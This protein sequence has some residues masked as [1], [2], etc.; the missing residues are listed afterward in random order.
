MAA[1]YRGTVLKTDGTPL[2]DK[3]A[4]KGMRLNIIAGSI[5]MMFFVVFAGMPFTMFMNAIG[6]SGALIGAIL[7]VQQLAM[8]LQVPSA[9]ISERLPTRK[10]FWAFVTLPHRFLWIIPSVIP[11]FLL[12]SDP[13]MGWIIFAAVAT[14]S[15][16]AQM[17][18]ASWWSWMADFIPS[19]ARSSFWGLRH[20]VVSASGLGAMLL[21][22]FILDAFPDPRQPG[23]SLTGFIIVL[24]AAAIMGTVDILLHMG[25]PEPKPA[26]KERGAGFLTQVLAPLRNRDFRWLTL[27][28]A[29]WAFGVGLINQFGSIWLN[30]TFGI[31]YSGLS[32]TVIGAMLG[33]SLAGL[34]WAYVMDRVGARNFGA[35]MMFVAPIVGL[36][37][38]FPR[39]TTLT[40]DLPFLPAVH[41]SQPVVILTISGFFGGLLYSG[42]ALAQISLASSLLPAS[43]RTMAMAV[44]WSIVGAVGA[45]GPLVAGNLLDF[46][47]A[48]PV[49]WTLPTGT[50]LGFYHVLILAQIVITWL[51]AMRMLLRIERRKGEMAFR[52]ALSSLQIGNP[53]RAFTGAYNIFSMLSSDSVGARADAARKIGEDRVRLAVRDLIERLDDP[54]YDV[55]EEAAIALGKI[56]S[57]DAVE[58]L[59]RKLEDPDADL[60]PV[61]AR[62]LRYAHDSG[63][64]DALI[65]RLQDKDR[66]TVSETARTLGNIGDSRA[67]RA[68]MEV[69]R[70]S[71]DAKVISASSVAL[72]QLGEMAAIYDILPRMQAASNP[73]LKRTLA[74]AVGDLL[75]RPGEF[76]RVFV[77]EQR[78][79]GL[80]VERMLER[81]R[82]AVTDAT[83]DTLKGEGAR[84]AERIA[85]LSEV[86]AA[87]DHSRLAHLM[88]DTSIALAAL[89]YGIDF[90]GDA[91]GFVEKLVWHDPRF[92]VGVWYL[93][94]LRDAVA[95]K[96]GSVD[97][98]SVLL[99]IYVLSQWSTPER[100]MDGE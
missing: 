67:A 8:L 52:T 48:H 60:G 28:M 80:E 26:A 88:F 83:P 72:A 89:R 6:A 58:A 15:I 17:G 9:W 90:G 50:P 98:T 38:F 25:V 31:G 57:P 92:G 69:L 18:A 35:I 81:L 100:H 63:S 87:G 21:A 51:I 43:G 40:F 74:V 91:E 62:A 45:L 41:L 85:Q 42:V 93:G 10:P 39:Q 86:Y 46:M 23:G 76:Y 55:R 24:S 84:V 12:P 68:L 30:R 13:R 11:L 96:P 70:G 82:E 54:S 33:A 94:L 20:S 44:H 7:T 37:W 95:Q 36:V 3:D 27:A 56:G 64:V 59:V 78:D 34:L 1:D 16:L 79:R 71:E 66:E 32:S 19:R 61:I 5:G 65:R 77:K 73:V 29:T 22:G 49:H 4:R 47:T 2:T 97:E 53:L 75:G 99:G 14:S